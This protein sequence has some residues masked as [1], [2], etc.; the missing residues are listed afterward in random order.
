MQWLAG[1]ILTLLGVTSSAFPQFPA[2]LE[3]LQGAFSFWG[4][5]CRGLGNV[6]SR[7]IAS[8]NGM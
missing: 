7:S 1:V 2:I 8:I 4:R 5:A 6:G 3:G